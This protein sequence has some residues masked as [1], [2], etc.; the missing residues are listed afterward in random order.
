MENQNGGISRRDALKY[1]IA[2]AAAASLTGSVTDSADAQCSTC[3][4]EGAMPKNEAFYKDG[5]FDTEAAKKAY[6]DMFKRFG[7]PVSDF[8]KT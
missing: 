7:Y 1:S 3:T 2:G 5:S 6:F 4:K 8:L